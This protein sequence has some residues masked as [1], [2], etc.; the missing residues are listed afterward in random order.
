MISPILTGGIYWV[1]LWTIGCNRGEI[2]MSMQLHTLPLH[3]LNSRNEAGTIPQKTGFGNLL[4]QPLRGVDLGY[5]L[6]PVQGP[7]GWMPGKIHH[8]QE[9]SAHTYFQRKSGQ[10]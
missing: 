3:L 2:R 5:H 7:M 6:D 10:R 1:G 9:V 4:T 8:S